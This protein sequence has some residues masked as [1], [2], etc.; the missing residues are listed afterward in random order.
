MTERDYMHSSFREKMLEHIFV[1]EVLQEM[2]ARRERVVDVLRAEVDSS[3]YDI[4]FEC[5]DVVRHVQLRSSRNGA[6]T[7]TQKV[8]SALAKKPAGCV[9]WLIFDEDEHGHIQLRYRFFGNGPREALPPL[10]PKQARHTK[11]DA[12]GKK[13]LRPAIFVVNKGRFQSVATT[14]ELVDLLFGT[15]RS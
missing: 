11:A 15:V 9:V 12:T 3:G 7:A 5:D 4:V 13:A 14:P 1:A 10:G 2:W 6:K 8:N